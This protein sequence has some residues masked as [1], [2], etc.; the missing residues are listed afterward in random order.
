M[1]SNHM[2][3]YGLTSPLVLKRG[4]G[5]INLTFA[6]VCCKPIAKHRMAITQLQD[7]AIVINARIGHKAILHRCNLELKEVID[8]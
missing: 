8:T 3:A 1:L 5:V 4:A 2:S 7:A 6:A